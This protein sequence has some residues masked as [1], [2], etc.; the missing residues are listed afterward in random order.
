MADFTASADIEVAAS[1]DAVWHALTDPDSVEKYFFGARVDTDWQPGSP[2]V[3]RGEFQGKPFEDKGE[4][5]DV[6]E[7][8]LLRVT[9]YSPLSGLDDV[10]QNYHTLTFTLTERDAGTHVE[11]AQDNNGSQDEADRSSSNWKSMLEGLKAVVED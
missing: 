9:H 3:W 11:L 2:I 4:I 6:E 10:P 5:V 1:A 8:R 7:N